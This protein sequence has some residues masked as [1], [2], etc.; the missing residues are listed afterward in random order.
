M[1][2]VTHYGH[3]AIVEDGS[4]ES[5]P[6]GVAGLSD[7]MRVCSCDGL[8]LDLTEIPECFAKEESAK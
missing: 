8:I 7:R 3:C 4:V 1:F 2:V 6:V 5:S